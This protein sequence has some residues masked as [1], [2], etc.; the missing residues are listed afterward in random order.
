MY[1]K[2]KLILAAALIVGGC[3][4]DPAG[5]SEPT[6]PEVAAVEVGPATSSMVV[7]DTVRLTAYPKAAN[8]QP[9]TGITAVEW[10]VEPGNGVSL[11]VQGL[12]AR[13]TGLEVGAVTVRAT[14][15]G[16]TGEATITVLLPPAEG[17]VARV[18]LDP[19]SDTLQLGTAGVIVAELRAADG[20]ITTDRPVEWTSSDTTVL[21]VAGQSAARTATVHAVGAGSA[22][23]TA[24]SEGVTGTATFVVLA[25]APPP[26]ASVV[27]VAPAD[28]L[29]RGSEQTIFVY[30]R[31]ADGTFVT[32]RAVAWVS[33][34]TTVLTVEPQEDSRLATMRAVAAGSAVVTATSEGVTGTATFVVPPAVGYVMVYPSFGEGVWENQ[35]AQFQARTLLS[36]GMEVTGRTIT[37]SVEDTLVARIDATTGLLVGRTAG[38]TRVVAESEGARGYADIHVY[39]LEARMTFHLTYD[40]WDGV[41]QFAVQMGTTTWTDDD[42][43]ERDVSLYAHTGTF[44]ID[45]STGTWERVIHAHGTVWVDGTLRLVAEET[46]SDHGAMY[47][48]WYPYEPGQ[49]TFDFAS[50]A[51]PGLVFHG[52]FRRGGELMVALPTMGGALQDV[53]FRLPD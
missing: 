49:T 4:V 12:H 20:T 52:Y 3:D 44:T 50:S 33:S 39:R 40:W 51:T 5:P 37:F 6:A 24:T 9:I 27:V 1:R 19:S 13:A 42:G 16:R 2:T 34:D 28:T 8:G 36:S 29:P 47:Y 14:V 46:Y 26:V 17:P 23:V 41:P 18:V 31:T 53:L 15:G 32:D 10:S 11:V 21:T 22:T 30:L 38:R 45:R 35:A 7:G 25:P 48:R 43:V